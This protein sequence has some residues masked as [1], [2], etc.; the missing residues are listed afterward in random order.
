MMSSVVSASSGPVETVENLYEI[1][2]P[3]EVRLFLGEHPFLLPLLEEAHARIQERFP[4]SRV[5]LQVLNDPEAA[6]NS[7]LI[8][9]VATDDDPAAAFRK[10]QDLDANWWLTAMDRAEGKFHINLEPA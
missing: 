6:A 2:R 5:F 3:E 7:H 4:T 9:F 10:L 8:A 1:R